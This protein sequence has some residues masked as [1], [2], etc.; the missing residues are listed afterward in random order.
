M[1]RPGT[2]PRSLNASVFPSPLCIECRL[3]S[4]PTSPTFGLQKLFICG[5]RSPCS[6]VYLKTST[7]TFEDVQAKDAELVKSIEKRRLGLLHQAIRTSAAFGVFDAGRRRVFLKT[8]YSMRSAFLYAG[9]ECSGHSD[10]CG[11]VKPLRCCFSCLLGVQ[12]C[13]LTGIYG[14]NRERLYYIIYI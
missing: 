12:K 7:S 5:V 4:H 13:R 1:P 11:Q 8:R 3:L 10:R 14:R 2:E 6:T 9:G